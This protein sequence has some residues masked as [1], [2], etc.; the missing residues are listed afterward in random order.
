M[1]HHALV[2]EHEGHELEAIVCFMCNN[3]ELWYDAE[4]RD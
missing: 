3:A 1:P 2:A 4:L